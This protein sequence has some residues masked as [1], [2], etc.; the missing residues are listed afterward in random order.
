MNNLVKKAIKQFAR[1]ALYPVESRVASE[2]SRE[3]GG[4]VHEVLLEP[5]PQLQHVGPLKQL[6]QRRPQVGERHGEEVDDE[7]LVAPVFSPA[8][9]LE[10]RNSW[11]LRRIRG[12][13]RGVVAG[14]G[15]NTPAWLPL[16]VEGDYAGG[17]EG[18]E[19]VG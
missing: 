3:G 16:G 6:P 9:Q 10:N 18:L 4:E 11:Q 19:E 2:G 13:W 12:G 15:R 8:G 1:Q 5:E 7:H 17:R 14:G